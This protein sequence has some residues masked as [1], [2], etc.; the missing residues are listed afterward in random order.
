MNNKTNYTYAGPF[1]ILFRDFFQT[2]STFSP[3]SEAKATHPLDIYED[4]E[5]LHFEIACT[6]LTKTDVEIDIHED[7]LKFRYAKPPVEGSKNY[8][9]KGIAKRSFELGYKIAPKFNL[10][11]ASA[12][13]ENGL[14]QVHIPFAES[15]KPTT[16]T[17]K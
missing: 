3:T 15:S 5:G 9:H 8:I 17:I 7:I 14:L 2:T 10:Q 1:D 4:P 12:E 13:M 16:L 11:K 6:G